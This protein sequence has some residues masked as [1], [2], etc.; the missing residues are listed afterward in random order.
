M[1]LPLFLVVSYIFFYFPDEVFPGSSN[2]IVLSREF[3]QEFTC[4]FD[5]SWYP[6][7]RQICY[8]NFTVQGQTAR[9]LILRSDKNVVKYFG[10]EYLVEYRVEE[11][12]LVIPE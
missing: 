4:D 6:F 7:D 9:S 3:Y 11:L 10:K 12:R 8:M 1:S 5:L 2:P